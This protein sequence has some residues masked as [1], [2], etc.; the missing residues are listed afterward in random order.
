MEAKDIMHPEDAKAIQMLKKLRGFD[1]LIRWMMENGYEKQ[2]RGENLGGY[3]KIN[4]CNYKDIYQL[5][6]GVVMKVGIKTSL[7]GSHTFKSQ[8][9]VSVK[10][11]WTVR[12]VMILSRLNSIKKNT[13]FA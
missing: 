5:F 1:D 8:S 13:F 6:K 10:L 2:F 11:K 9:Y 7:F 12:T 3:L 4:D